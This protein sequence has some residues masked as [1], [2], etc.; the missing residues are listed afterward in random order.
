MKI[1]IND[2]ELYYEEYG[3]GEPIIFSY[4]WLDDCSVWSYQIETFAKNYRAIL[5]DHRGHG[6][7]DKPDDDYSVQALLNDLCSF[8]QMLSLE[9]VALV[10]FSLGGMVA[11]LYTLQHPTKVSKLILVGTAAKMA[12]PMHVFRALTHILPYRTVLQIISRFKFYSPPRQ[13]IK[14][15]MS[16]A[17]QVPRAVAYKCLR[18]F[19]KNYD[20][21][22]TVFQIKVPTL[23]IVGEKDRLNLKE[24][25]H[26]NKEIKDSKLQII[27]DS[28]HM[29]MIEKPGEFNQIVQQ[30]I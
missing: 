20:I 10:G 21:R 24:S 14:A 4:G 3:K 27:P 30:F 25:Q 18:E 6:K 8:V 1:K 9:K 11:L 16:R 17:E 2:I 12:W 13:T 23:I 26:L 29:V 28:G 22:N 19:T 7:S 5:Y 15:N